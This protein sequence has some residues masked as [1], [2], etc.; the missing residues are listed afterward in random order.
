MPRVKE[1]DPFYLTPEWRE[2]CQF[3]KEERW[4]MLIIKQGHCCEDP[5][6]AADHRLGQRIFFDHVV[7]LR[8]GGAALDPANVMGRCGS[9]HTRKTLRERARRMGETPEGEGGSKVQNP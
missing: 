2:L 9:S 1:T 4:P 5:D 6:C 3:L 8:D 7:E